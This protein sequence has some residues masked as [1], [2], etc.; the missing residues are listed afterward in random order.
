[1]TLHPQAAALIEAANSHGGPPIY[2]LGPDGAREWYSAMFTQLGGAGPQMEAVERLEIPVEGTSVQATIYRPTPH[3][4]GV[5]VYLHGGGWALGDTA[6]I[7]PALRVLANS[8]GL[9]IVGVDYRR[10]PESRF[11]TAVDDSFAALEWVTANLAEGRPVAVAGES[12]GGSLAAALAL[13]A[14]DRRA[15]EVAAQVLLCPVTDAAM[16]TDSYATYGDGDLILGRAEMA[17]FWDLY[18]GSGSDSDRFAPE[19]S[20][21]RAG[22][23]R[24]L[25]PTLVVL[26]KYD[27]LHDEGL[28]YATKLREAGVEVTVADYDDMFHGFPSLPNVLH[29]GKQALDETAAFLGAAISRR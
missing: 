16:D 15:P 18:T 24:D 7:D 10:S 22:D 27:P 1:M 8:S 23:H 2:E 19:A 11:P 6:G 20:P 29:R 14:R 3:P 5:V 26:A 25:P 13:R 28:A 21:L 4:L 12:A 9:E 17:W